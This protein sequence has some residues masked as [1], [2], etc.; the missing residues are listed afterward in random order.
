MCSLA[1]K[2]QHDF[3]TAL[4][5]RAATDTFADVDADRLVVL[6][7]SPKA[8]GADVIAIGKDTI[9]LVQCKYYQTAA[10]S[11][12]AAEDEFD[13]MESVEVLKFLH[14][15]CFAKPAQQNL[16]VVSVIVGSR[17][18][19]FEGAPT[20]ASIPRSWKSALK[21]RVIA[22]G[23][24]KKNNT[25]K[26]KVTVRV[27]RHLCYAFENDTDND[28]LGRL[29]PILKMP[30]HAPNEKKKKKN[31][32]KNKWRIDFQSWLEENANKSK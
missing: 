11:V 16:K 20:T 32:N 15:C 12:E 13:K 30:F 21:D 3:N 26:E 10:V 5:A 29:Y 27:E 7:N 19:T 22:L 2:L 24:E 8:G 17:R 14:D 4:H 1:F 6:M 31:N 18:G 25:K 23:G 28:H 9:Y